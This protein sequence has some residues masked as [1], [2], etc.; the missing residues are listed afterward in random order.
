M[1]GMKMSHCVALFFCGKVILSACIILEGG[2]T[3]GKWNEALGLALLILP[4]GFREADGRIPDTPFSIKWLSGPWWKNSRH[5]I[6]FKMILGML[7]E[8][9][10]ALHFLQSAS[11]GADGRIRG[12]A[13]S[14]KP[15]PR[16][17]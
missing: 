4:N 10:Q 8:E 7:M 13:H 14:S 5:M 9:P 6:F 11:R 15:F 12:F 1:F 17:R 2:E 16:L 3:G